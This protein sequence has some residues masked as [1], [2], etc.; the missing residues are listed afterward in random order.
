[1]GRPRT[2]PEAEQRGMQA[3]QAHTAY[4]GAAT[5]TPAGKKADELR[6]RAHRMKKDG[7]AQVA[8]DLY[9]EALGLFDP[10]DDGPGAAVAAYDLAES[11]A[12]ADFGVHRDN[13]REAERLF[14]KAL[15][16]PARQK[17]PTRLALTW[18][19]LARC[20][21]HLAYEPQEARETEALL[22]EAERCFKQALKILE[23]LGR[24]GWMHS[25]DYAMNLGNLYSQR[26]R[27]DQ[28]IARYEETQALAEAVEADPNLREL[29][30]LFHDEPTLPRLNANLASVLLRRNKAGD[31]ERALRCAAA[32]ALSP[33]G[34]LRGMCRLL[35]AQILLKMGK[36]RRTEALEALHGVQTRELEHA[37]VLTLLSLLARY[38]RPDTVALTAA[39]AIRARVL[40]R[41]DTIADHVA[42]HHAAEAQALAWTAAHALAD[43]GEPAAIDAFLLLESVS[44]LRFL[45]MVGKYA[46]QPGDAVS[47]ALHWMRHRCGHRAILL[48]ELAGRLGLVPPEKQAALLETFAGAF[49]HPP[50]E[51][52]ARL[53]SLDRSAWTEADH[54]DSEEERRW[55]QTVLEEAR[56]HASPMSWLQEQARQAL[57]ENVQINKLLRRREPEQAPENLWWCIN[58]DRT[59]LL[60][61]LE[62]HPERALLRV[63]LVGRELLLAGVWLERGTLRARCVILQA[64]WVS[65]A[66]PALLSEEAPAASALDAVI[67]S[68][69]LGPAL[70]PDG[71]DHLVLLPNLLASRLPL[72]ALGPAGRTPLDR[73]QA[74]TVL[75]NLTPLAMRQAAFPPRDG[76]LVVTPGAVGE[77]PTSLHDQALGA[78]APAERRLTGAEATVDAVHA[79]SQHADVVR[80]YAHGDHF[81]GQSPRL[82]L[83]DEA[84]E[85]ERWRATWV[86]A[87][88]VELWACATGVDLPRD[89]LSPVVVDEGFGLD[90]GLLLAGARSAL[91]TLW[92]VP[93]GAAAGLLE[94]FRAALSRGRSAPYALADAQRAWRDEGRAALEAQQVPPAVI[95][96]LV[97]PIAW[98]GYRFVGVAERRPLNAWSPELSGSPSLEARAEAER[99][100]AEAASEKGKNLD[101]LQMERIDQACGLEP[102]V[103]PTGAQAA[104]AGRAWLRRMASAGSHSLLIGLAWLH[105]ALADPALPGDEVTRLRLE[106]AWGWLELARDEVVFER[107]LS[108]HRP[109]PVLVT[110]G[111]R[112]L[113]GVSGPMAELLRAWAA[114][115]GAA[116]QGPVP[117]HAAASRAL[118]ALGRAVEALE[119]VDARC[120]LTLAAQVLLCLDKP[121]APLSRRVLALASEALEG[122]VLWQDAPDTGDLAAAA[123]ALASA[124]GDAEEAQE[125][126]LSMY[127][128]RSLAR[129][130]LLDVRRAASAAGTDGAAA[131]AGMDALNCALENLEGRV[132]GN[133]DDDRLPFWSSTGTPG[134]AWEVVMGQSL[135]MMAQGPGA[136]QKTAHLIANLQNGCDLRLG[137]LNT[138][139][140]LWGRAAPPE[141][142]PIFERLHLLVW[143]REQLLLRLMG[144][145]TVSDSS[146]GEGPTTP[147]RLDPFT[148]STEGLTDWRSYEDLPAWCLHDALESWWS[149]EHRART[150]AGK[151]ARQLAWLDRMIRDQWS[152]MARVLEQVPEEWRETSRSLLDPAITLAETERALQDVAEGEIIISLSSAPDQS[153]VVMSLWRQQD[154]PRG[155]VAISEPGAA[156]LIR[157]ALAFLD[158]PEHVTG[159]SHAELWSQ[160]ERTLGPLLEQTLRLALPRAQ[161]LSVLAP[162]PLRGMPWL[163]LRVGGRPLYEQVVVRLLPDTSWGRIPPEGRLG[164]ALRTACAL[165]PDAPETAFGLA[166][167]STLRARFP[168]G[169]ALEAPAPCGKEFPEV[170]RL[171]E[172]ADRVQVLRLYGEGGAAHVSAAAGLELR[173]E[174]NLGGQLLRHLWLPQAEVVELWA[175][176]GGIGAGKH[177][178][179]GS[180]DVFPGLVWPLLATGAGGLVDL[181][182][183]VPDVVRAL[184]AER[185]GVLLR[186]GAYGGAAALREAVAWTAEVLELWRKAGPSADARA[187]LRWLDGLRLH[188]AHKEGYDGP[189][190]GFSEVRADALPVGPVEVWLIELTRPWHLASF[191]WWGA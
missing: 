109:D 177:L 129:R 127:P 175:A 16:S 44:G 172:I 5:S 38:S 107:M 160:I 7:D 31:L 128:G 122:P 125:F 136:P 121:P 186:T 114:C 58:L 82:H 170:V 140:R 68:V 188:V 141:G 37:Q 89:P 88:R 61:I 158:V 84:L 108:L 176:T 100:L 81:G 26:G 117:L 133:P 113:D 101:E 93:E 142:R 183:D 87:E 124:L 184:V 14:R 187:A 45:D 123:E 91:G 132:W 64:A 152:G 25:G 78:P 21:R 182:W 185:F 15:A 97:H 42:D 9:R 191:R 110:R 154:G 157:R 151:A 139:A 181:A 112:L 102:G 162:G 120:G 159:T 8:H 163:G 147:H 43:Q 131:L 69:D 76:L 57:A 90:V 47:A 22:D 56:L 126:H 20:L 36:K 146:E 173:W 27:L 12:T 149:L 148:L 174:R 98:A 106:A 156:M 111:L 164:P 49:E 103:M 70:P 71:G 171:R 79:A 134:R 32:G 34:E 85:L 50:V 118:P 161:V 86:G 179:S 67:R 55:Y 18:D 138:W 77:R 155:Q 28:A 169:V 51:L 145:A 166:A 3:F 39:E 80:F 92:E 41:R 10:S 62:E 1:M 23:P 60:R 72:C 4:Q 96:S 135:L 46:W 53:D 54:A 99:L 48:D 2:S 17:D 94:R 105:E 33:L 6:E 11:Y 116:R 130:F 74:I 143:A 150:A 153:L 178:L 30:A 73:F 137:M 189:V 65:S 59:A 66:L 180:G 104:E 168:S 167:L 40:R 115:L 119:A 95:A 13:L 24:Y 165:P 190:R 144:A 75:P 52:R 29:R 83:A 63:H 19:G 35:R